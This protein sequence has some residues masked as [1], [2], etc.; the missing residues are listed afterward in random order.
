[1]T[2]EKA[3]AENR[4]NDL[5]IMAA[6]LVV[7]F[8]LGA[9]KITNSDLWLHLKAGWEIDQQGTPTRDS[10]AYTTGDMPWVNHHWLFDWALYKAELAEARH[11]VRRL[12]ADYQKLLASPQSPDTLDESGRSPSPPLTDEMQRELDQLVANL[13]NTANGS[14]AHQIRLA[15]E[16]TA[17]HVTAAGITL[18][19]AS[20]ESDKS[21]Y[22]FLTRYTA[23]G[24][25]TLISLLAPSVA[26]CLII[27]AMAGIMLGLRHPGPTRWW[28]A[29]VTGI[30]LV[31]MCDRLTFSPEVLSLLFMAATFWILHQFQSGSSWA[32]WL[33]V[34]LEILWVNVDTCF[35]M[36]IAVAAIVL[37]SHGLAQLHKP[38]QP[39]ESAGRPG[40]LAGAL[41]VSLFATLANPFGLSVWNWPL[42]WTKIMLGRSTYVAASFAQFFD[43]EA[44]WVKAAR[45][46][47]NDL[48]IFLPDLFSPLGRAFLESI[49]Q[50][51]IVPL[52]IMTLIV[53]AFVSFILN[54]QRFQLSRLLILTLCVGMFFF[55]F[56]YVA[57]ASLAAGLMLALNGQEWFLS[58]FGTETRITSGWLFWSLAGR[59]V[60]LL[61]MVGIAV[62]GITGRLG[63]ANGG[64]FGFGVQWLSFD[65]EAGKFLRHAELK[66]QALNTVA[67]QGNLLIW[68]NH[69]SARVFL[70]GRVALHHDR[71]AEF[72]EI[73]T[74]LRDN[75][76][77]K[78]RPMLDKYNIS[79]VILNI[80]Q[81]ADRVTFP[82][83]FKKLQNSKNWKLVHQG[84][85]SCIFGRID[86]PDEHALAGDAAW[87]RGNEL[88]LGKLVFREKAPVL[89]DPPAPVMPPTLID[90]FWRTRLI[91][92]SRAI[93]GGHYLNPKLH[94]STNAEQM[95]FV[96]P[97]ENCYLAI[98]HARE[99]LSSQNTVSP[100]G[101]NVLSEAYFYLYN[102]E[103]AIAPQPDVHELR[104]LELLAALNQLVAADPNNVE[105]QLQLAFRYLVLQHLDL[106]DG[107][108]DAAIKL[109][110]E[111]DAPRQLLLDGGQARP[112]AKADIIDISEKL[113]I[114]IDRV[115]YDLNQLTTQ[116]V[117]PVQK[118]NYFLQRGCPGLAIEQLAEA[119]IYSPGL[120]LAPRLAQ[121]YVRIGEPGDLTRGA[122]RE[123]QNM[124][125]GGDM[126]PGAVEDLWATVKL[127]QGDYT[128]ARRFLEAAIA[129][130][131]NTIAQEALL[132]L[133]NN[134]RQGGILGMAFFTPATS[135][136]DAERQAQLEFRLGM[137]QLEAGEPQEAAR[138]FKQA[139]AVR[140]DN[141]FRPLIGFYLER[142]TG[143]K[144]EP[145]P[146]PPKDEDTS[147]TSPTGQTPSS[148]LPIRP[149][150]VPPKPALPASKSSDA[151]KSQGKR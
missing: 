59:A 16:R 64:E 65:L 97:I 120:D 6:V 58:R 100:L 147:S 122:E 63:A 69:P 51:A 14:D 1:M 62:L 93:L 26:K 77:T 35:V 56:R 108:L 101:Y 78:W 32:V 74:A 95:A 90:R 79:H 73:K 104:L 4:R 105:A 40:M 145:L 131:R 28:T 23:P 92:P 18:P 5:F 34:P 72:D 41:G 113:K 82:L 135:I 57:F 148:A 19:H 24:G 111:D 91:P 53:M 118:A 15:A 115:K 52:I 31:A 127:M 89:P 114:D 70:D 103:M 106:A 98:R 119:A 132:G 44:E 25:E 76:E 47:G 102:M 88:D 80:S 83:T 37:L 139:L 3:E 125:S 33:L 38:G 2:P 10:F 81:I 99:G 21:N 107:H 150:E 129:K 55:A 128:E 138:H 134:L 136:E 45:D 149:A 75:D 137:L 66:G 96:V 48:F 112:F 121:L 140:E 142:I 124:Q 13:A 146:E 39:S 54:R 144:L 7:A 8:L 29:V 50:L 71:I 9:F 61:A 22:K 87:F 60:T 30:S 151:P 109:M 46:Q 94:T 126:R 43:S 17:D 36:G 12:V 143:E 116:Q 11:N 123:L 141:A 110:R 130:T 27:A 117:S 86:F 20:R 85:A 49:P 42:Q 67:L 68:S 84:Y 133:T